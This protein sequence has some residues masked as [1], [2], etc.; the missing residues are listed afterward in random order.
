MNCKVCRHPQRLAIEEELLRCTPLRLIAQRNAGLSA[1]SIH[2]HRQ[3]LPVQLVKAERAA[4]A[5][6]PAELLTRIADMI[7][8]CEAI[9]SEAR[10]KK[11]W[12][13]CIAAQRELRECVTLLAR[14][15]GELQ[16]QPGAGSLHLHRHQHVHMPGG[17]QSADDL[18]LAI[19]EHVREATDN[20]NPQ[21][22]ERLKQLVESALPALPA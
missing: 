4:E 20:F 1:W 19:A 2:R 10:K 3:H 8:G 22:I 15:N 5:S 6:A 14:V 9:I 18:E 16:P 11:N 7:T 17:A 12:R 21:E 13:D